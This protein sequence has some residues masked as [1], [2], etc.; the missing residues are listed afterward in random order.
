MKILRG[1]SW[2]SLLAI[3]ASLI[4]P[5]VRTNS[6]VQAAQEKA[7]AASQTPRETE[8]RRADGVAKE[9]LDFSKAMTTAVGIDVTHFAV[10]DLNGDGKP[11]LVVVTGCE[12]FAGCVNV[13]LGNGD[14]SFSSPTSYD[15]G[16]AGA[17]FVTIADVNGDGKPDLIVSNNCES[18]DQHGDCIGTGEVGVLLG[19]GDG[20]FQ[21]AA[22]YSSGGY[23]SYSL[24][25]GDLNGDG[26]LDVVVTN[27]CSTGGQNCGDVKGSVGVLLGNGDGTFQSAAT[28]IV[29]YATYSVAISDLRNDGRL[30]LVV[31]GYCFCDFNVLLGN[32]DGTFQG[33]VGYNTGGGGEPVSVA[34][35]DL[36]ADGK[37][38][39][40]VAIFPGSVQVLL[41]NGDGT[42][43]A[44]VGY[45]A[46]V[47]YSV[48]IGDVNG[49]SKPDLVVANQK[50]RTATVSVLLG[51]GDGTFQPEVQYRSGGSNAWTG[52]I[53][54]LNGDGRPDLVVTNWSSGTVG[55]LLN[56]LEFATSTTLQSS[57]DPC[58]VNQFVTF[59]ATVS[60]TRPI[61]DGQTVTFY[62]GSNEIGSS[63]T[64]NGVATLA[65]SFP[66]PGTHTIR[67]SFAR[68][69]FL[70]PSSG[71]LKQVVNR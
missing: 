38:D 43:Q 47:P 7:I 34:V 17:T 54:D 40:V 23:S 46:P 55:V 31:A 19:N 24:A 51:N 10:A 21:P 11:D 68:N 44:P 48:A 1:L 29:G 66:K 8:A 63:A 62:E 45:K 15:T 42:F 28:Y 13:L 37:P 16:G 64:K 61:P 25:L 35:G 59:T 26:H 58:Q 3:A 60:A 69:G 53:A 30:D 20:T 71:T 36:N 22:I 9:Q 56:T 70:K 6:V 14:G 32:G 39:L 67:G 2:F 5:A 41:G 49:D 65:T 12:Q 57:S 33:A 52:V 4:M 18:V 50:A 27:V